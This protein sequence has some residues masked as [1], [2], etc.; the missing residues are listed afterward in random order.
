MGGNRGPGLQG[1]KDAQGAQ[2]GK[3]GNPGANAAQVPAAARNR[4]P[5]TG[6]AH[7]A[8]TVPLTTARGMTAAPSA[9]LQP[10]MAMSSTSAPGAGPAAGPKTGRP[11]VLKSAP[12]NGVGSAKNSGQI[13]GLGLGKKAGGTIH[14]L[15]KNGSA[16]DGSAMP[17][18]K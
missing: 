13:S 15:A 10:G 6:L 9:S 4:G 17:G 18:K 7:D 16:I 2:G 3:T 14:P 5:T 12:A 1:A 8:Q 11:L